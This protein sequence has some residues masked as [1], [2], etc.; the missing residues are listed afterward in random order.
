MTNTSPLL[1]IQGLT[2]HFGGLV[3]INALDLSIASGQIFALVGPNGAG[4]TTVLNC[5]SG[6]VRPASG[7]I[8]FGETELLP[9][10][11]DRR[12]ALGIS[13]TFQNLQLFASMTVLENLLTAQHAQLRTGLVRALLPVGFSA[14][15]EAQARTRAHETLAL[16]DLQPYADAVA[17]ALPFGIQQ[18]VGV[19][20]TLVVR[21]RLVLLDEPAAGMAHA[22]V[23]R[24]ASNL[25]HWRD[26]LGTTLVVIEH[27]MRLVQDAAD[28]VC[29]LNYGSKLAEG[30]PGVV[31]SDPG[32]QE[33]YLGRSGIGT[34]GVVSSSA[35]PSATSVGEG[36]G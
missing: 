4:K 21:P 31:L 32:V 3:A 18:L 13:R 20:R 6:F 2:V 14:R 7:A 25:R 19:A 12:A 17:G 10:G 36:E 28:H 29:A 1:Q 8:R 23:E 33:A 22:D 35:S 30:T 15:E 34:S 26:E 9:L 16:L 24:L 27:N 11:R 5:I